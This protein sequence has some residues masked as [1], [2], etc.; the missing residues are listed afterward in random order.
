MTM[1]GT[2]K[3]SR[4]RGAELHTHDRRWQAGLAASAATTLLILAGSAG[5]GATPASAREPVRMIVQAASS[6][7]AVEAITAVGG[8]VTHVLP[9]VDG[10]AG[11]V[12][13]SAV[14]Q[15]EAAPGVTAVSEDA[16]MT[17]QG[18]PSQSN[19]RPVSVYD[20]V[21]RA[22]E[23]VAGGYDGR[24]VT[25][26]LLDTG[27]TASKDLGKRVLPV[28]GFLGQTYDCVNLSG[29]PSCDDGYGH[30]TF[31]AGIIAGDGS[32]SGGAYTGIAPG[33]KLVSIKVAS[34]H[35]STDVSTVL[36][37][38]QW[39]VTFKDDYGI[40]V[41]NLA[42]GTDSTQSWKV[43]PLNRA[44]ERAWDSGLV[45]V[46]AASNRGPAAGTISKPGDDPHVITVG[47]VDDRATVPL[48]DDVLPDFSAH[49]PTAHGI[50]KP[51]IVAPGAH[52]V[53]LR[54]KGSAIDEQF[55]TYIDDTYRQGSGTSMSTAVV[56]GVIA[57]M[58][59]A[60]PGRSP[61]RVKFALTKTARADAVSDP[62]AVGSGLVDAYAAT[63]EAPAGEANQGLGWSTGLGALDLSRGNVRI[64]LDDPLHTVLSGLF[65]AQ[66]LPWELSTLLGPWSKL[67]WTLSP[68]SLWPL[69]ITSDWYGDDWEG[70]NWEGCSWDSHHSDTCTYGHNWEGSAWYGAWD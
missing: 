53:S 27:I 64:L 21:V 2:S 10:A 19:G 49:G 45:V 12:P 37:G 39:A 61:N 34:R 23:M 6:G 70:H 59:S 54:A 62:A 16:E 18:T 33:A 32:A 25:V 42:Y 48:G 13:Q 11:E 56:S 55:P 65:T 67:T 31:L 17:L 29:D 57:D 68:Y 60:A 30:G 46:V 41:L 66:L 63:F 5:G 22:D 4:R 1:A 14:A 28:K 44:V 3:P 51:D 40:R 24:G 15:L 26:A 35:G 43:D 36:A 7:H 50:A 20:E 47:A 58:L 69:W 8:T 9:I 38:I 52:I